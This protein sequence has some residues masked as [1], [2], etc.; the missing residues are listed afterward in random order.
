[1]TIHG[2]L[3][4]AHSHHPTLSLLGLISSSRSPLDSPCPTHS[5]SRFPHWFQ[6]R[7]PSAES[8]I[9]HLIKPF[10][11]S[12]VT[13]PQL[14]PVPLRRYPTKTFILS[15]YPL[16]AWAQGSFGSSSWA[17]GSCPGSGC[18]SPSWSWDPLAR[19][20]SQVTSSCLS[21]LLPRAQPAVCKPIT[22]T[23][24]VPEH[25]QNAPWFR[26]FSRRQK[27]V[28][29]PR[30]SGTRTQRQEKSLGKDVRES[31]SR[32]LFFSLAGQFK[33]LKTKAAEN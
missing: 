9:S 5:Q 7:F 8:Q 20:G 13:Q 30:I 2:T 24:C 28:H 3:C 16:A 33:S 23:R 14:E 15:F 29:W 26:D 10:I 11:P 27:P 1:M 6:P 18:P 21:E 22:C 12:T 19:K 32:Q 17:L 4:Q 31:H 25:K